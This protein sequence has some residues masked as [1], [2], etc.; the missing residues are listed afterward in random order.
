MKNK[1]KK[2]KK[3]KMKRSQLG[4]PDTPQLDAQ[5]KDLSS[6]N[7]RFPFPLLSFALGALI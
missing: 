4:A 7:L 1:R 3:A 5:A 2:S 6:L